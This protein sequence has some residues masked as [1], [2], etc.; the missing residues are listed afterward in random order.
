MAMEQKDQEL[1]LPSKGE[2]K[3]SSYRCRDVPDTATSSSG[4][5]VTGALPASASA[6]MVTAEEFIDTN[7]DVG[8]IE[9][10]MEASEDHLGSPL[11]LGAPIEIDEAMEYE[12]PCGTKRKA[13]SSAD[14]D[15]VAGAYSIKARKT[16]ILGDE[17]DAAPDEDEH[18]A[19]DNR[20]CVVL[21]SAIGELMTLRSGRVCAEVNEVS[22]SQKKNVEE[23]QDTIVIENSSDDEFVVPKKMVKKKLTKKNTK[24]IPGKPIRKAY[25]S[26]NLDDGGASLAFEDLDSRF[27]REELFAMRAPNLGS[28]GLDYF[29]EVD[30]LRASSSNLSDRFSGKMK[31]YLSFA[32]E[33]IRALV[34]KVETT[35]DVSHLRARN[36]ELSE[37]LKASKIKEARMQK[38]IDDLHSAILDLRKEVRT[39]KDGGIFSFQGT[40]DSRG[41]T[42]KDSNAALSIDVGETN[43]GETPGCSK[44][45]DYMNRG[46]D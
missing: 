18:N 20:G 44:D 26:S 32:K 17:S 36:Y 15:G 31:T 4:E 41:M 43:L 3:A 33:V 19:S 13:L 9:G 39:L 16:R 8:Q 34:E 7:L 1:N 40:K 35:G 45:E 21:D 23:V 29:L 27:S 5:G 30:S 11:I 38:E 6:N 12:L 10:L 37:E 46:S 25:S 24:D 2:I 22:L 42:K 14:D 28:R